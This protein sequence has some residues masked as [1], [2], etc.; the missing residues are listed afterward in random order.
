MKSL[1]IILKMWKFYVIIVKYKFLYSKGF[2]L[3]QDKVELSGAAITLR[4]SISPNTIIQHSVREIL[5]LSSSLYNSNVNDIIEFETFVINLL[6]QQF[7]VHDQ[8][9]V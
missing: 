2:R 4:S 9:I 7:Q 5:I 1:F 8:L 3:S 6:E